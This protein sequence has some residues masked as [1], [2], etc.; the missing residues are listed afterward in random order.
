MISFFID[1][2]YQLVQVATRDKYN[3]CQKI[4][5]RGSVTYEIKDKKLAFWTRRLY[6]WH[7]Q[8][9][10]RKEGREKMTTWNVM[11]CIHYM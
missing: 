8:K 5:M 10:L 9:F 1:E 3:V 7:E 6:S 4:R 2:K 11:R